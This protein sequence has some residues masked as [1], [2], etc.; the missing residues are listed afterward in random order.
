MDSHLRTRAKALEALEATAGK[1]HD[2]TIV[3]T[4]RELVKTEEGMRRAGLG[5]PVQ[6]E[7]LT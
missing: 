3:A 6:E 5:T 7:V 1:V 4:L 2:A